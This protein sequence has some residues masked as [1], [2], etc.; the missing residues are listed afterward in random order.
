MKRETV[1]AIGMR[2]GYRFWM[3]LER[4]LTGWLICFKGLVKYITREMIYLFRNYR[5]TGKV[6]SAETFIGN[7]R[8]NVTALSVWE[9]KRLP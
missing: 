5:A 7:W 4:I 1:S 8:V 2:C 3:I 6:T 9:T